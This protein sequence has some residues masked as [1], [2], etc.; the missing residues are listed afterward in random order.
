MNKLKQN[1][2]LRGKGGN[3][4]LTSG[5]AAFDAAMNNNFAEMIRKHKHKMRMGKENNAKTGSSDDVVAESEAVPVQASSELKR[6][7]AVSDDSLD[8]EPISESSSSYTP[9]SAKKSSIAEEA[10]WL[11]DEPLTS[12]PKKTPNKKKKTP[13][14]SS[15]SRIVDAGTWKCSTCTYDNERNTSAKATCE[16]CGALRAKQVKTVLDRRD[17]EIVNID[18]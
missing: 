6:D 13:I 7:S 14:P 4:A 8:T 9:P 10:E 2:E 12:R 11:A 16:M 1:V 17:V 18:C 15:S 5:D 3:A